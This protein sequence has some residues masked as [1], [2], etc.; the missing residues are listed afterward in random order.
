MSD[1]EMDTLS[2]HFF[3]TLS[4]AGSDSGLVNRLVVSFSI[5]ELAENC[6]QMRS[7]LLGWSL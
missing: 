6:L 7:N 3:E 2:E 1:E 4:D 5:Q